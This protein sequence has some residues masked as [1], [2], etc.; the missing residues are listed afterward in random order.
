[1]PTWENVILV[2]SPRVFPAVTVWIIGIVP[3]Y[4]VAKLD[5]FR[6]WNADAYFEKHWI[7]WAAMAAW[8]ALVFVSARLFEKRRS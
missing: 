8:T 1:M 7:I 2:M 4:V 6:N 3:L 5:M